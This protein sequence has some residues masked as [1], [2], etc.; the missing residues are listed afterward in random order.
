[1]TATAPLGTYYPAASKT[2]GPILAATDRTDESVSALR[3]A[4]VLNES[5]HVGVTVLAVIE[6]LPLIV[7]EPSSLLQP[8]VITPELTAVV[9]EQAI[10]QIKEIGADPDTWIVDVEDGRPAE[11]I[12]RAARALGA[13]LVVLGLSHHG[14][15]DRLI[16]GDTAL[17]LLR[18]SS[19]PVLLASKEF[20]S[21]PRRALV[22][23]DFSPESMAAARIGLGLLSPDCLLYLAHVRPE[24]T[25]FDGS[26]L[27]EEEYERVASE[28]LE[29]FK[30]T[31]AAPVTMRVET[32]IL[33]GKPAK[34]LTDFA[35]AIN[36]DLIVSGSHGTGLMRRIF[37]GSTASRLLRKTDRSILI[38]PARTDEQSSEGALSQ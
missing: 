13:S 34:A 6:P 19:T 30:Q 32:T 2:T 15:V 11:E 8:L 14:L 10:K 25:I 7:P 31:L 21:L 5:L 35:N 3:A 29:N 12:A 23:V 38:V 33:N 1:M 17:D 18:D 20:L 16:D 27:W 36:A 26:G 37:I 22:A 28:Q 4:K 9:R 24:V